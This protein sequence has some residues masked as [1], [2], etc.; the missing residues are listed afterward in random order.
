MV[1]RANEVPSRPMTIYKLVSNNR[2]CQL[3]DT[4]KEYVGRIRENPFSLLLGNSENCMYLF[5]I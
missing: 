3:I 5:L 1:L 2:I 4:G